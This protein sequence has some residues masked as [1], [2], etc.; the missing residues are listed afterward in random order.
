LSLLQEYT[1]TFV[2]VC[3]EAAEFCPLPSAVCTFFLT[4]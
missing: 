2:A 3:W 1:Y 4:F